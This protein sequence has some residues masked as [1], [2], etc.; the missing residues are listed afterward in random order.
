M[1]VFSAHNLQNALKNVCVCVFRYFKS[2][3]LLVEQRI[4]K[5]KLSEVVRESE[6]ALRYRFLQTLQNTA[7]AFWVFS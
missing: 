1:F 6:A 2:H 5:D 4:E 3:T 7:V